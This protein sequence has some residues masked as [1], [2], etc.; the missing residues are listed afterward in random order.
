VRRLFYT[1]TCAPRHACTMARILLALVLALTA[2]LLPSARAIAH[3]CSACKA[4]GRELYAK[5]LNEVGPGRGCHLL[6][7]AR[8]RTPAIQ[9]AVAAA[10]DARETT[11]GAVNYPPFPW[12]GTHEHTFACATSRASQPCIAR[13]VIGCP[14]IQPHTSRGSKRVSICSGHS[15]CICCSPRTPSRALPPWGA[16]ASLIISWLCCSTL[17]QSVASILLLSQ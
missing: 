2:C 12:T 8:H 11:I 15:P 1:R 5:L 13:H 7:T 17:E 9:R 3:K 6:G 4:V 16:G 14:A 10:G